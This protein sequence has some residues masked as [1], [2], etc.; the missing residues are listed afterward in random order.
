MLTSEDRDC[1]LFSF[2]QSPVFS[3]VL[4]TLLK[5][6]PSVLRKTQKVTVDEIIKLLKYRYIS[7]ADQRI[8]R[9][10]KRTKRFYFHF[11]RKSTKSGEILLFS[12]KYQLSGGS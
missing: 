5:G 7:L 10:I 2:L 1:G 12:G 6:D 9:S 8:S 3:H 11:C 4:S